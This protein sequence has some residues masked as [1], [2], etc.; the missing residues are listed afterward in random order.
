MAVDYVE[1]MGLLASTMAKHP[2]TSAL[3][4]STYGNWSARLDDI[5]RIIAKY[6]ETVAKAKGEGQSLGKLDQVA[7]V[8]QLAAQN[9]WFVQLVVQT[10][11]A[12]QTRIPDGISMLNEFQETSV[13]A[14]KS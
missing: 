2:Q 9:P 12:W 10:L 3:G 13:A 1:V 7:I 5:K 11:S 6:N 8:M 4:S 14:N